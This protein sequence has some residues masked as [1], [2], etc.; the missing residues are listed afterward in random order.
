MRR[1]GGEPRAAAEDVGDDGAAE[2]LQLRDALLG[3]EANGELAAKAGAVVIGEAGVGKSA[4]LN[5]TLSALHGAGW[6]VA[7]IPHA[8]DWT[9]GLSA[10]S[11]Q[12][13]NEA[14]RLTDPAFFTDAPPGRGRDDDVYEAPEASAHFVISFY[15]SQREK[16]ATI[17]IKGEERRAYYAA[18]AADPA[19]GPTLADMLGGYVRDAGS[20][21]DFPMAG[22]PVAD[23]LAELQLVT[24]YPT[25]VVI[26]G[27]TG[28]SRW[29]PRAV[30]SRASPPR[31]AAPRAVAP[32]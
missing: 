9:L 29:R 28:C 6:L 17:P 13:A 12:A 7:V 20:F 27:G 1:E 10:R 26:D 2:A 16:L 19:A 21:N 24:E 31:P 25:A 18:A 22:R 5:Y 8:A 14:Y 4:V 23:L 11:A 15:L 30:G 32:R 3:A